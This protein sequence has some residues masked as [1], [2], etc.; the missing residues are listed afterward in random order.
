VEYSSDLAVIARRN[1]ERYRGLLRSKNNIAVVHGDAAQFIFPLNPLVC[2]FYNPF[3]PVVMEHVFDNLTA[4]FQ[5]CP[6][7]IQLVF[8]IRYSRDLVKN[9]F[10]ILEF[11]SIPYFHI[12]RVA[13]AKEK[14]AEA[15]EKVTS[16]ETIDIE[17]N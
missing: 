12:Y 15:S 8:H 11:H 2:Y 6:R 1:I 4:S 16:W 9:K 7:D 5:E 10:D 3:G 17:L 13:P 14:Q